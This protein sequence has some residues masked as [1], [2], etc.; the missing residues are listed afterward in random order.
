MCTAVG[1]LRVYLC[2]ECGYAAH[3]EREARIAY[4]A[5]LCNSV[6]SLASLSALYLCSECARELE[7]GAGIE[8][9]EMMDWSI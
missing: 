3:L 7:R 2:S 6:L 5:H 4:V 1:R 8:T 9:E